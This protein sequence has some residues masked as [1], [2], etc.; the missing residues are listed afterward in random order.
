MRKTLVLATALL[1]SGCATAQH[2]HGG[3]HGHRAYY[4]AEWA[5]PAIIGGA[6]LYEATRPRE[7]IVPQPIYIQPSVPSSAV[8]NIDGRL[9]VRKS[10]YDNSCQ[11]YR[12]ALVPLD[13]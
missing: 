9:Y 11:C 7:V 2:H 6:L 12:S 3:H 10:L 8:V 5:I 1:M 13:Q 4:G